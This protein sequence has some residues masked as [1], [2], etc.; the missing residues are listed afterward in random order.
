MKV[1]NLLLIIFVIF[2]LGVLSYAVFKTFIKPSGSPVQPKPII[3]TVPTLTVEE[4]KIASEIKSYEVLISESEIKTANLEIKLHDQVKFVNK[5]N[6]TINVKGEGW[7]GV[8][9][10]PGENM[11]NAFDKAGT[12]SYKVTEFNPQGGSSSLQLT[13]EVVVK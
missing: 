8:P 3:K 13:G 6:K 7:G 5:T 9:I 11:Y 12:F 10:G 1:K 4:V 2:S